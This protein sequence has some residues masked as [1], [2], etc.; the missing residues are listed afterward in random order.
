MLLLATDLVLAEQ[1]LAHHMEKVI[2]IHNND[3][4]FFTE[5]HLHGLPPLHIVMV[6]GVGVTKADAAWGKL[7]VSEF[8]FEPYEIRDTAKPVPALSKNYTIPKQE[9]QPPSRGKQHF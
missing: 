2:G 5:F 9:L 6:Y 3:L 8:H 4:F 7:Q 1:Y